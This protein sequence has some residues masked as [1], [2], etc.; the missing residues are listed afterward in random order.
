MVD[1][2]IVKYIVIGFQILMLIIQTIALCVSLYYG[3]KI[4]KNYHESIEALETSQG[5]L[6]SFYDFSMA[7]SENTENLTSEEN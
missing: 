2:Q 7:D 5:I 3:R 1:A 6:D 4:R